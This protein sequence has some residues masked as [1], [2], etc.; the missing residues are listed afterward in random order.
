[1]VFKV[2]KKQYRSYIAKY[3]SMNWLIN[4][5]KVKTITTLWLDVKVFL[6]CIL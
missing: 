1:M 5:L 2:Q 3:I 4:S 6:K